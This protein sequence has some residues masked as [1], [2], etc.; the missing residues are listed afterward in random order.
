MILSRSVSIGC[1]KPR[2]L[3][4]D[5]L[6]VAGQPLSGSR[7]QTGRVAVDVVEHFGL[8]DE[9]AAIDPAAV[10]LRLL[11]E[12]GDPVAV[13]VERAEAARRLHRG[14]RRQLPCSR[15][16]AMRAPM[17]TSDTPSP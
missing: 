1:Q 6:A 11:R 7:S 10:A 5:Q 2:G 13:D 16:K 4:A 9:E 14:H 15:W 17:S 3:K 8:E 12:T